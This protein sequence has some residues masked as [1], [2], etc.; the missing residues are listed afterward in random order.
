MFVQH[1]H[2]YISDKDAKYPMEDNLSFL[3][4]EEIKAKM[5]EYIDKFQLNMD[6]RYVAVG[7]AG[8][9]IIYENGDI[10]QMSD[11]G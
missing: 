1:F 6:G 3:P 4:F 5:L 9:C 7:D 10:S 8:D 11:S 2:L